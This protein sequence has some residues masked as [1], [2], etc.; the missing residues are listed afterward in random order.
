[1]V[2]ELVAADTFIIWV[3][4]GGEGVRGVNVKKSVFLSGV[5]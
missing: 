4:G 2:F 5:Q 3:G 1:M